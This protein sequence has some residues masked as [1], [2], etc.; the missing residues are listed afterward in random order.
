LSEKGNPFDEPIRYLLGHDP[1]EV[2]EKAGVDFS[3]GAFELPFLRWK[4]RVSHPGFSFELPDFLNT[5]TVKLLTLLYL[6]RADGVPKA[7]HWVPYR[8]LPDG[9]F[10]SKSFAETVEDR[11]KDRFADDLP[12]I[13]EA[14]TRLGCS[15][16]DQGDAGLM[17]NTYPRVSLLVTFWQA[18]EEFP[19]SCNI[20]FDASACHYLNV[21][22]LKMLASEVV[23]RMIGI[24][25]GQ[26]TV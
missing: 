16:V 20:L 4:I 14:G 5:F 21:F 2:A 9:L 7:N 17:F 18:D 24:A 1:E 3:G 23:T 6:N 10:Y 13:T 12:G 25:N 11:L 22:E 8:E 15:L 26:L 19:A